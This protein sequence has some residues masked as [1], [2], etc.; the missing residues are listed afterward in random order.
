MNPHCWKCREAFAAF[1]DRIQFAY[2]QDLPHIPYY[3]Q[4]DANKHE[5]SIF[6]FFESSKFFSDQQSIDGIKA[7]FKTRCLTRWSTIEFD[8][9]WAKSTKRPQVCNIFKLI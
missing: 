1:R 3:T 4:T 8:E 7:Y 6:E 9:L 5:I 2:L